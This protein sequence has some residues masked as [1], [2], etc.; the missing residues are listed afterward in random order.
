MTSSVNNS[1]R[2]ASKYK[3]DI[4]KFEEIG[5][6]YDNKSNA[7]KRRPNNFLSVKLKTQDES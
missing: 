6:I 3:M 4:M 2:S 7:D 1:D 5:N